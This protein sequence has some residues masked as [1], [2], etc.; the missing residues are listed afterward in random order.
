MAQTSGFQRGEGLDPMPFGVDISMR[1]FHR[2]TLVARALFPGSESAVILVKDGQAWRSRGRKGLFPARDLAAELVI[3]SGEMLWVADARK[4]PRFAESPSVVAAPFLRSYIGAPIRLEDGTS[5]GV[6]AVVGAQPQTFD[7]GKAAQLAALAEFVADE[8][9]RAL[10]TERHARSERQLD[11]VQN[12]QA[13]LFRFVPMSL[14]L[15]DPEMKVVAASA[16][17]ERNMGLV[18]EAYVGCCLF[19]LRPAIYGPW[20]N[21]YERCLLG[22]EIAGRRTQVPRLGR[23]PVWMQVEITAW[24]EP[25]GDIGGLMILADDV[26]ELAETLESSER[27]EE[28]LN[29]ALGLADLHV[30]E[31]DYV[32]R[33]MFK[34]GAEDTFFAA[35]QT[36]E[37]LYRDIFVTIDP[38]D[39]TQVRE[40]WRRHVE[41]GAPYRPE[42]RIDRP[43]GREVWVQGASTFIQ[44]ADGS[45]QRLVGAIQD[46]TARKQAERALMEAKEEAEAANR[47]KSTFLATMS[48]EIRTPLNGVLG[49]A[50]AM[51]GDSLSGTQAE[52]LDVIRQSG[53]TLL[54]ILNDVLDLSKIE[55]G[56]LEL[57]ETEFE[58]Q[59]LARGAYSAFTAIANKKGLSFAFKIDPSAHGIYRGDSTRVRQILYNLV[60]NAIKFTEH[61][62]VAVQVGRDRAGLRFSVTD[63]GIGIGAEPLLRLFGKFEQADASTTRRFGGTGLGLAISKEFAQLMGGAI[64]ARSTPGKGSTFEV[65][66]PLVRVGDALSSAE[67]PRFAP[68]VETIET[69]GALGA[70]ERPLRVLAAE[71]NAVNQLVLKTLLHQIGIALT[72]VGDGQAAVEAWEVE[73][74]DLILMDIQMPVVDG[75]S[76]C[77]IIRDREAAQGRA[78]TPIVALTANAMSHQV[79]EY[80]AVGMD[81]VVAK[82]IEVSKLIEAMNQALDGSPANSVAA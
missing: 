40:A 50:Q 67:A 9:D 76:A 34:A 82:P 79:A 37:E 74:W 77:R 71:D 15:T 12:T 29:L 75:P 54:A 49:M 46:I 4:D 31:L 59:E 38:R 78:R 22:E 18:G 64:V 66:L 52:R 56:K 61:G 48:H 58:V 51:S 42:Y 62:T 39:R 26:S 21:T 60:S 32:R 30:F 27:A 25:T 73:A 33:E 81:G 36:Y 1:V 19:D 45:P 28:R 41:E 24:R 16:V 8:W 69:V 2:A 35:P 47:A 5:P 68:A 11:R 80:F 72:V 43:D 3:A 53:E 23:Q 14:V 44:G 55:A 20:R 6:L 10:L 57:E 13:A 65:T 7:A 63:T 70:I 17:W